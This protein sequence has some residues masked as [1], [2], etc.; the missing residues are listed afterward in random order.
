MGLTSFTGG[1]D[2][3]LLIGYPWGGGGA[4]TGPE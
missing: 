4:L 2:H 3:D 1:P